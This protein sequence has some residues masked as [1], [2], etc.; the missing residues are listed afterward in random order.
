MFFFH[1]APRLLHSSFFIIITTTEHISKVRL[2]EALTAFE[3]MY[4]SS[5]EAHAQ[6]YFFS[7]SSLSSKSI[8]FSYMVNTMPPLKIKRPS[9]GTAPDQSV[10]N[11]SSLTIRAAQ[12]K[13]FLY[14]LAS[15]DCILVLTVSRGMV[16]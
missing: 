1:H 4:L 6:R 2:S 12:L 13:L 5:S 7:G 3:F 15:I 10:R 14:C 8:V 11:P 9:L 16:T